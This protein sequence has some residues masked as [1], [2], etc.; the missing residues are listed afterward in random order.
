MV[1]NFFLGSIYHGNIPF[2]QEQYRCVYIAL[3]EALEFGNT[4]MDVEEFS[5]IRN[6]KKVFSMGR[7]TIP[8]FIQVIDSSAT[9]KINQFAPKNIKSVPIYMH[10]YMNL[11]QIIFRF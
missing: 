2:L 10:I 1:N 4:A 8:K 11:S 5:G 7:M 3:Y 9:M 6:V